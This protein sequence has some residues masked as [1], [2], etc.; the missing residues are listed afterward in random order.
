MRDPR[1]DPKAGA[2]NPMNSVP[3]YATETPSSALLGKPQEADPNGINA[4]TPGAKL[5]AG[6]API[7]RGIFQYFPRALW[8]VAELSQLGANKYSWKGWEK[9][10]DGTNRYGDA[11]GRHILKEEIEGPYDKDFPGEDMLHATEEAWNALARLE[12][13]L[14][15]IQEK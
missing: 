8:K 3:F 1:H 6:K 15:D 11:L 13:I 7:M 9:V 5:D 10:P 12:L 2:M 4:K 14:R